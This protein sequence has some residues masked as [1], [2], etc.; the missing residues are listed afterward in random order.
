MWFRLVTLTL[1]A[2]PLLAQ[3]PATQFT[4]VS[5]V[6]YCIGGGKPLLMDVFLPK[7]RIRTPTPAVLWIHGGG[8]ERGDK[9]GNSGAQLLANEG[10]VTASLFYHLSGDSP[11]PADQSVRMADAYRRIGLAVEFI[12]V[13]NAGH[14]FEHVGDAPIS[15]SVEIIHQRTI[16]FFKHYLVSAPSVRTKH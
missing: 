5:D 13:K 3:T 9:N 1:F 15:P 7:N 10:F 11:F 14:D 8:W 12:A 4:V 6:Q 2:L 16:D